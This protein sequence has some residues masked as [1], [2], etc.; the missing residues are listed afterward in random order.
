MT[1]L[2]LETFCIFMN[3]LSS[4]YLLFTASKVFFTI[5]EYIGNV[6]TMTNEKGYK[7]FNAIPRVLA[8]FPF[9]VMLLMAL[10]CLIIHEYMN[11]FDSRYSLVVCSLS[12]YYMLFEL[13][14]Y[15]R[16]MDVCLSYLDS[17]GVGFN[18]FV[19]SRFHVGKLKHYYPR[20]LVGSVLGGFIMLNTLYDPVVSLV[21][22][23]VFMM[24]LVM[25]KVTF[26]NINNM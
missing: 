9:R 19:R 20:I 17:T 4:A 3:I 5:G 25:R 21:I 24:L 22:A 8:L 11:G 6:V 10:Q 7:A 16:F 15:G 13:N 2:N 14:R 23:N 1:Y 18:D 26:N 12:S